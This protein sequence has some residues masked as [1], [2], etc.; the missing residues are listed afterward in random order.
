MAFVTALVVVEEA[1]LLPLSWNTN[2]WLTPRH[3]DGWPT[4]TILRY[5]NASWATTNDV[6]RTNVKACSSLTNGLQPT[7]KMS[8]TIMKMA[9]LSA[10]SI[11]EVA[12]LGMISFG[13]FGWAS[14]LTTASNWHE[15]QQTRGIT[16]ISWWKPGFAITQTMVVMWTAL[17]GVLSFLGLVW[18][19]RW[20]GLAE[21][22]LTRAQR[23]F[24][25]SMLTRPTRIFT[26]KNN[27]FMAFFKAK[28]PLPKKIVCTWW[29]VTPMWFRC[30]SV[31]LKTL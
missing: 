15:R 9:L 24:N 14:T 21:D 17:L 4:N 18:A 25:K 6:N 31:V 30:I 19:E 11:L 10:C 22:C 5:R 29:R 12:D 1:I 23:A 2:K 26:T 20:W 16:W 3:W 28:K 7:S 8:Y 13:S 27:S